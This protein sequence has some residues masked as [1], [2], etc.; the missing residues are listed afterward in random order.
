V[1]DSRSPIIESPSAAPATWRGWA[2]P[3]SI[4]IA[5]IV[6][7]FLLRR[8]PMTIELFIVATLIAYGIN[9]IIR[10]LS[11]RMPRLVAIIIVYALFL[12]L[13]LVGAVIV[14][15][16]AVD[17]L[18]N[19]VANSGDYLTAAQGFINKQEVWIN[20]RFGGHVL[21]PQLQNLQDTALGRLSDLLQ[22]VFS[23][24][25]LIAV[26]LVN[27]VVIGI[28]AIILSYYFLVNAYLIRDSFLGLFP[29]RAKAKATFF[30]HEMGRVVGG[31]V[32]GQIILSAFCGVFT[33][34]GLE[35]VQSDYAVLLGV[36]TGL[37]YAIPYLGV[38]AAVLV[39]LLLGLLQSWEVALWTVAIMLVITKFADIVL[40]PKVMSESVGVSPMAVI[41]AVFAGGELF[42]LWGLVLAIPAAAIFKCLWVVW[43]YPW[44]TGRSVVSEPTP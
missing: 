34:F 3:V 36:L 8:I 26:S 43:L 33:F 9:P 42:G 1:I 32:G 4:I 7:A 17:Q 41:F 11:K 29:E 31:F 35:L 37:F 16:T 6:I 27:A 23:Q 19:L 2:R 13:M 14:I 38:F 40:V 5:V 12:V 30:A 25:G 21:P 28:T 24:A 18:Q 20:K 22:V 15:P 10:A 39:G 44:L